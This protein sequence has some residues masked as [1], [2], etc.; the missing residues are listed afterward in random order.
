MPQLVLLSMSIEDEELGNSSLKEG[1]QVAVKECRHNDSHPNCRPVNLWQWVV[2]ISG[3]LAILWWNK[4]FF[5]NREVQFDLIGQSMR[6][7]QAANL[8]SL[9]IQASSGERGKFSIDL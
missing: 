7:V 1:E 8:K 3:H 5:S 6:M 2:T 9:T 4:L